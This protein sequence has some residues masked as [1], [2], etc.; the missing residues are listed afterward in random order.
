MNPGS[1]LIQLC[2]CCQV[3]SAVVMCVGGVLVFEA[4]PSEASPVPADEPPPHGNCLTPTHTFGLLY[5]G[6]SLTFVP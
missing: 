3:G 6:G 5:L 1:G 2:P 4:G